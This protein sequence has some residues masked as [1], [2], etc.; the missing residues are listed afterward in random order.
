MCLSAGDKVDISQPSV[1]EEV[2]DSKSPDC[3]DSVL[4][5][6]HRVMATMKSMTLLFS[7]KK[8]RFVFICNFD[9]LFFKVS[10]ETLFQIV[11][12]Q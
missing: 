7:K 3:T 5:D 9:T 4:T 6:F 2:C 1:S 11:L 12:W 8:G 10:A